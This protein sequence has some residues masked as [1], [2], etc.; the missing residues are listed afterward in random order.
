MP[1]WTSKIRKSDFSKFPLMVARVWKLEN[2]KKKIA[3][4]TLKKNIAS[5][6]MI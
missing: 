2:D 1:F 6:H 4:K 5:S 3:L